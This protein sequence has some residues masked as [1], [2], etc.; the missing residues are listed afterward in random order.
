VAGFPSG[1][2]YKIGSAV[3]YFRVQRLF[4]RQTFDLGGQA[5]DIEPDAN[6]L[7]GTRTADNV[8]VTLGKL[9]VTD[10]FDTNAYAHDR[11]RISEL[12]DHRC[13]L[14]STTPPTSWGYSYGIATEWTQSWWT[15]RAGLF[16]LSTIPNEPQLETG[17]EQF[18][19]LNG[20]GGTAHALGRGWQGEAAGLSQSRAHGDYNDAVQLAL[21]THSTPSTALVRQYASRPGGAINVEQQI[22][23]T[24]GVFARASLNDGSKEAYEFTEID[25][26]LSMGVA[27]KGTRWG[28]QNDTVGVAGE[29][30]GISSSAQAYFAAG[31]I[32][33]L[34]GD[35]RL[36]HYGPE[37]IAEAYLQ[38]A[39]DRLA[40]RKRRLSVHRQTPPLT[41]Q[42]S[43]SVLGARLHAEF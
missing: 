13:G 4:L 37:Q 18:E 31:G 26:S 9:T 40:G 16:D 27:L 11:R 14:P 24:L 3:P 29:I 1:E 12:G 8:V 32:G 15:L 25:K 30:G 19:L 41:G 10:I 5:Q 43:V 36:P 7:G 6:Q 21:V 28:R 2:A 20:S 42:R 23:D 33:I 35:G 34:I 38:R 39:V 22:D 17:F